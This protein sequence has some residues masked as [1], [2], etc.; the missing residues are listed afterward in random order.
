MKREYLNGLTELEIIILVQS[1]DK[2]AAELLW[3]KYRKVMISVLWPMRMSFEEKESEAAD[4]FMHYLKNVF[5]QEKVRKTKEE[6]KF[7]SMLYQ[8]M[9]NR[10]R[11]LRSQR[12]WLSYDESEEFESESEFKVFNAEKVSLL[13]GELFLR[14]S[15]EHTVVLELDLEIKIRQLYDAINGLQ[16][17]IITLVR[18]GLDIKQVAKKIGCDQFKI[19][20]NYKIIEKRAKEIF[21]E[22]VV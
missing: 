19:W 14:Y 22:E 4:V 15:P 3:E 6:W 7:F 17:M 9:L 8:G 13:Y 21:K 18:E 16:K 2:N 11:K 10:R 12:V 5:N 1:G 20:C